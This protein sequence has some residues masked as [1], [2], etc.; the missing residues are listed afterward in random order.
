MD[1]I[2][3]EKGIEGKSDAFVWTKAREA[4]C[5]MKSCKKQNFRFSLKTHAKIF[6]LY[7]YKGS[8]SMWMKFNGDDLPVYQWLGNYCKTHLRQE[9]MKSI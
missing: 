4:H 2:V 9:I 3:E 1:K 6:S 8:S 7:R 5:R